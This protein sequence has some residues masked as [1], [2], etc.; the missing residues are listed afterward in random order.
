MH[1]ERLNADIPSSYQR[2]L[3][4]IDMSCNGMESFVTVYCI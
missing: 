1:F 2:R 3:S 4:C